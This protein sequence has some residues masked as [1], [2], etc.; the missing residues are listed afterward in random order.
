MGK[1]DLKLQHPWANSNFIDYLEIIDPSKTN[2]YLPLMVKELKK[3]ISEKNERNQSEVTHII[4]EMSSR[5]GISPSLILGYDYYS[6]E[7][8]YNFLSL[9]GQDNIVTLMEFH[10]HLENNRISNNDISKYNSFDEIKKEVA[11]ASFK[12]AQKEF[13]NS[14]HVVFEDDHWVLIKPLTFLSSLKYGASTKWC[15]AMYNESSYFYNYSSNGVLIYIINKV[16]HSKVACHIKTGNNNIGH[17]NRMKF[18]NEKDDEIDSYFAGFPKHIMMKLMEEYRLNKTNQ[19]FIIETYPEIYEKEW[20]S[21]FNKTDLDEPDLLPLVVEQEPE[22]E[23]PIPGHAVG[24]EGVAGIEG[25]EETHLI[26]IDLDT[27]SEVA[28]DSPQTPIVNNTDY[29]FEKFKEYNRS[30]KIKNLWR[31]L[32]GKKLV[33]IQIPMDTFTEEGRF[34]LNKKLHEQFGSYYMFM[35]L[36]SF[37]SK[38]ITFQTL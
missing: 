15:T 28:S 10:N 25:T 17:D 23:Y 5:Y 31:K 11:A 29:V 2:K 14:T 38:E 20:E 16:N 1:R 4:A 35:V 18:Y 6:L 26:S 24:S 30:N 36:P 12:Q 22:L 13:S 8:I 19:E 3:S 27:P 21:R 37:H 32:F 9:F 33:F 7:R 34:S